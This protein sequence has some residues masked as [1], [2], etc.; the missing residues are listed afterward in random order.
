[1]TLNHDEALKKGRSGLCAICTESFSLMAPEITHKACINF[2]RWRDPSDQDPYTF[3]HDEEIKHLKTLQYERRINSYLLGRY[4]AK[5]AISGFISEPNLRKIHIKSGVFNQPVVM[6]DSI[7]NIQVS[8]AHSDDLAAAAA[9][10]EM[11]I[12][13]V[14]IEKINRNTAS[15]VEGEL[16]QRERD[17]ARAIAQS[18][19][20]FFLVLWTVKESLSKI[21]KTGLTAPLHILE[22]NDTH[23]EDGCYMSTFSNFFQYH[24]ISWIDVD[25]VFSMTYPKYLKMNVD[26]NKLKNNIRLEF[27]SKSTIKNCAG[28][29]WK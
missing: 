22:V 6:G 20:N 27:R 15:V 4:S 2:C 7:A 10:D 19:E 3:L 8:L 1:M 13:G 11:I 12:L 17:L 14:D 16:T 28:I 25:Y 18:D 9:F 23:I 21:L 5:S 24:T 26:I 29:G